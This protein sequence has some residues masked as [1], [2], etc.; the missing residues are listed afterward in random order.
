E[1]LGER[2]IMTAS[3]LAEIIQEKLAHI[4]AIGGSIVSAQQ[5]KAFA[6]LRET[7]PQ[8]GA[9]APASLRAAFHDGF[10]FLLNMRRHIDHTV[11]R[12]VLVSV[13]VVSLHHRPR[14][15]AGFRVLLE[16]AFAA[17]H[18]AGVFH[19]APGGLMVGV[20]L[21]GSSWMKR[22]HGV[23]LEHAKDQDEAA[24]D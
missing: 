4:L 3:V 2:Q 12:L 17:G 7:R 16:I 6:F 5:G 18:G 21:T 22:E 23:G 10:Y 8:F 19:C 11:V 1:A 15:E 14:R 24:A 20:F 13:E 9:S